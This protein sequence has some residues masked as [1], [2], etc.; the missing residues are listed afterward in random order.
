M[1]YPVIIFLMKNNILES[2]TQNENTKRTKKGEKEG[3]DFIK[4]PKQKGTNHNTQVQ[5]ENQ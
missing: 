3:A 4:D 5:N 1:F 2:M